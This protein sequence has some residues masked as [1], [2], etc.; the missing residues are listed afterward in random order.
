MS[1]VELCDC[2]GCGGMFAVPDMDIL[3]G[4]AM[5]ADCYKEL[6]EAA[7]DYE[8]RYCGSKGNL[9]CP[10]RFGDAGMGWPK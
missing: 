6:S 8:C 5:C 2:D 1:S 9:P 10:C 3:D 7:H 4:L